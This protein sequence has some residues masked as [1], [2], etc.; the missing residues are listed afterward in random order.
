[1]NETKTVEQNEV[2]AVRVPPG[3]KWLM[4]GDDKNVVHPSLMDVLEAYYSMTK[5]VGDFRFSPKEGK[6]Y[7]IK[8]R[9]EVV[10]PKA[11]KKYNI[12]G[13]PE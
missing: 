11:A 6:I 5:F 10:I 7:A 9:E 3:D 13:D 2:I 8:Q 1:M 12:Y 4:L